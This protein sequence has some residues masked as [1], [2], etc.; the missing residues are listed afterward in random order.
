[1]Y[2]QNSAS[3]SDPLLDKEKQF[4]PE[5]N[6]SVIS[7]MERD[8]YGSHKTK[9]LIIKDQ[10]L[11]SHIYRVICKDPALTEEARPSC[12]YYTIKNGLKALSFV[13][14]LAGQASFIPMIRKGRDPA[15]GWGLVSCSVLAWSGLDW[16]TAWA[17]LDDLFK[18]KTKEEALM[19]EKYNKRGRYRPLIAIVPF[20][21][22]ILAWSVYF[23][24]ASDYASDE[25]VKPAIVGL[26]VVGNV[27]LSSTPI[28]SLGQTL[29]L[30]I[31]KFNHEESSKLMSR[32]RE[33][34]IKYLQNNE[35]RIVSDAYEGNTDRL[36]EIRALKNKP[37]P[38]DNADR[39]KELVEYIKLMVCYSSGKREDATWQKCVS[40]TTEVFSHLIG[41]VLFLGFLIMMFGMSLNA[42]MAVFDNE[43]VSLIIAI[44][45]TAVWGYITYKGNLQ[46]P[47]SLARYGVDK[48]RGESKNSTGYYAKPKLFTGL[49]LSSIFTTI[50]AFGG[51]E[52]TGKRFGDQLAG[53]SFGDGI[54]ILASAGVVCLLMYVAIKNVKDITLWFAR[55]TE[56]GIKEEIVK[57]HDEVEENIETI[58]NTPQPEL[59]KFL[60]L[61]DRDTLKKWFQ[62]TD[63]DIDSLPEIAKSYGTLDSDDEGSRKT[64]RF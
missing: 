59:A 63:A 11:A 4:P 58:R 46:G 56:T 50:F 53:E 9:A 42:G 51:A 57:F 19:K 21:G 17:I 1:M 27:F 24:V 61:F 36:H 48:V 14:V 13:L 31:K 18:L 41:V 33:A 25:D 16:R 28:W 47:V 44:F 62:F 26:S 12:L 40:G 15:I 55:R 39:E 5:L 52:T 22:G 10:L 38:H 64:L 60:M 6:P 3:P 32:T 37:I 23:W 35:S 2:K 43:V 20:V 8:N 49:N 29:D 7:D 30:T 34:L 45:V 54:K